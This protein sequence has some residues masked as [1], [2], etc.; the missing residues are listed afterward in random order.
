M[1]T[2]LKI[3][4]HKA[5]GY[6]ELKIENFI[7]DKPKATE[8]LIKSKAAGIN[9]AD[10]CVRWGLYESAKKYV[11]WPITPGFEFAGIVEAT[12][13][14]VKDFKVGDEVFGVNRFN[15]YASHITVPQHQ[16]FKKPAAISF[17]EAAGI[18]AVYLT[19][20]HALF[21]NVIIRPNSNI[22][23]HSAAGGVGSALVQMAKHKNHRV[24]G[25]VGNPAKKQYVS[26]LGADKVISKREENWVKAAKD[27]VG[28]GFD[29]ILDANGYETLQDGYNML[30]PMGKLISYGFHSMLPKK[31]GRINWPKIIYSYLKTPRFNPVN[32]TSANKSLI[33]FNLSF[34]FEH[35]ELLSAAM[36][37]IMDWL[38]KG[39][40][41]P[42]KVSI[43]DFREV[44]KAHRDIESGNTTGKLI[45][46]F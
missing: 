40:I 12:G 4:I 36:K 9:Y 15:A 39:A 23:I 31:G 11:G 7:P 35:Q 10:I 2:A 8:V 22:L 19:A 21:Q 6:K 18:P 29:V 1:S 38:Q 26:E 43:Y 32:M 44:A 30:A 3:V 24:L 13:E 27:F 14:E 33:T 20:Y 5:G 42:P 17:E 45:L 16:L 28:S 34:L 37:D 46:Q 41:R 25:I